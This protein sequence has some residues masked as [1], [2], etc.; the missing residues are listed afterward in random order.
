MHAWI[1]AASADEEL[2]PLSLGPGQTG[3]YSTDPRNRR[4]RG[5]GD[6]TRS[7]LLGAVAGG[8]GGILAIAVADASQGQGSLAL[9]LEAALGQASSVDPTRIRILLGV[10]LAVGLVTGA[11]FG[12]LTRRLHG[13]FARLVFG[14]VLVPSI[15]IALQAFVLH[16]F[17]PFAP[18][19]L[20]ALPFVPCLLG[21]IG[22][23]VCVAL[24]LPVAPRARR[25]TALPEASATASFP[26]TRRRGWSH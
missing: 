12:A 11:G 8:V 13:I 10:A 5:P 26:L 15:W 23:G 7:S 2:E 18:G 9:N 21:A 24:A 19:A 6:L 16:P 22:F 4:R 17:A 1:D 14:T 20:Q 3:A 25:R